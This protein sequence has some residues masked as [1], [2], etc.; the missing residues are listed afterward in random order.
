[1]IRITPITDPNK[2]N[3][4][5]HGTASRHCCS[6]LQSAVHNMCCNALHITFTYTTYNI[7]HDIYSV[8]L[9]LTPLHSDRNR[10]ALSR[11]LHSTHLLRFE[12]TTTA[13][14]DA[15]PIYV[16]HL[17]LFICI[18]YMFTHTWLWCTRF[19]RI[20]RSPPPPPQMRLL[21]VMLC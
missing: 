6:V 21:S 5:G 7:Y 18:V 9:R 20:S 8:Y 17:Y 11:S 1:M 13:T 14:T 2:H 19:I 12:M 4:R 3:A 10:T 15:P 16:A